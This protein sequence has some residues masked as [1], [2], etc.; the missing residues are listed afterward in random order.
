MV[1]T[2]FGEIKGYKGIGGLLVEK[3]MPGFS[4]GKQEKFMGLRGMPSC[5]LIFDNV[6]VPK[7][8][9]VIPPGEFNNL[10]WTFDI[11][12]CGNSAMCLGRGGSAF[13][14]AKPMPWSGR[15]SE[16]RSANFRRCSL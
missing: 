2:R 1:Y 14:E 12:R 15:L 3:G 16:G 7:K 11:E 8:N 13:A 6:R 9:V 10:M 4:F 5:D